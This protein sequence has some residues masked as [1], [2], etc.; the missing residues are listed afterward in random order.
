MAYWAAALA[1]SPTL[2]TTLRQGAEGITE[3]TKG[4]SFILHSRIYWS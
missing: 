3:V 4:V 1:F 2:R